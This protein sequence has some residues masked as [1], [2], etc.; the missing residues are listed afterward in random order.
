MKD[1]SKRREIIGPAHHHNLTES[2]LDLDR[3]YGREAS[4]KSTLSIQAELKNL[5]KIRRFVQETARQVCD[6]DQFIYDL[7]LAVDELATNIIVHGYRGEIGLIEISSEGNQIRVVLKDTA[8]AF[9]PTAVKNPDIHQ[10]LEE[11]KIGGLGVY[12][13]RIL[14]DEMTYRWTPEG[15]NE[16]TVVKRCPQNL[17]D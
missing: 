13:A 2:L 3:M 5:A 12:M 9:D 16:V 8:S 15:G 11:R 4:V 7:S 10:P 17:L 14:T 6:V 1:R